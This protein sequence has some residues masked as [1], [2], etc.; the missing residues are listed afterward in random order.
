MNERLPES[1]GEICEIVRQANASRSRLLICGNRSKA[2]MPSSENC[3]A[4]S[5]QIVCTQKFA[6]VVEHAASDFTITVKA[7]TPIRDIVQQ[8]QGSEQFLPFD[9]IL[10]DAGASVGGTIASGMNGSCRLRFGGLRDFV[11]GCQ[12]VDGNGIAFRAG[13]RVVKNAAG[14][15]LPKF[16]IGSAGR[17]GII[18]EATFKVFPKPKVTQTALFFPITISDAV[19]LLYTLLDCKL[20]FDALDISESNQVVVRWAGNSDDVAN[21]QFECLKRFVNQKCDWLT[22][23][24]DREYWHAVGHFELAPRESILVRVALTRRQIESFDR[25]IAASAINR[26]YSIAGNLAVLA[27]SDEAQLKLCDSTLK[28]LNLS[29]QVFVGPCDR[30]ILGAA[31]SNKFGERIKKALDPKA[32]FEP[33]ISHS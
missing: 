24:A 26:R 15:D 2:K 30:W 13:G 28:K 25:V 7:G 4:S 19:K 16:M 6:G 29:G 31:T 32:V 22:E 33:S 21:K 14:F 11:I 17:F 20:E 23:A 9:P 8:L 12:V 3:A 1:I 27:L 10:V 18:T 5:S